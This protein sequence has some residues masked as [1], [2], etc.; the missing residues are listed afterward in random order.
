MRLCGAGHALVH[1]GQQHQLRAGRGDLRS[2]LGR[3]QA[4][5][6]VPGRHGQQ[7]DKGPGA[8]A[9]VCSSV[10]MQASPAICAI[11]RG[12][13]AGQGGN[14]CARGLRQRR[15]FGNGPGDHAGTPSACRSG[16]P[17]RRLPVTVSNRCSAAG[18][19]A[20]AILIGQRR[21]RRQCQRQRLAL[22]MAMHQPLCAQFLHEIQPEGQALCRRAQILG[23]DA[24]GHRPLSGHGRSEAS[25]TDAQLPTAAISPSS[26]FIAGAPINEATR[27]RPG[28]GRSPA[29]RRPVRS[30]RHSAPPAGR[31]GH[32]LQ[33][34]MRH[35][36]RMVPSRCSRRISPRMVTRSLASRFDSGSS[37]RKAAGWRT[38][39]RPIATR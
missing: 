30:V 32:R 31:P 6:Q 26:R 2:T 38:T 33:L 5:L 39:A 11:M 25:A 18:G 37:N 21:V 4:A 27:S 12:D 15:Q 13:R 28:H 7:S 17:C 9:E 34:V 16:W 19:T 35:I 20:S 36:K 24:H 3:K 1:L 8:G 14:G 10:V 29:G 23:P 22:D